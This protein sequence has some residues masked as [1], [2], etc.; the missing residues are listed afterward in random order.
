NALK[1]ATITGYLQD[2]LPFDVPSG[3][4]D[5]EGE[6]V[7]TVAA[8]FDI[9]IRL[10]TVKLSEF[11]IAPRGVNG[12][13]TWVTLPAVQIAN[14]TFSLA[15]RKLAIGTIEVDNAKLD[16]AREADGQINLMRLAG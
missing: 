8:N 12:A 15:E 5:L 3:S 1:A 2:T 6:Y 13:P 4:V 9:V 14:T 7:A 16:V 11:N 10:P